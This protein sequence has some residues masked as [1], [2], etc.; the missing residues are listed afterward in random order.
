MNKHISLRAAALIIKDNKL[1]FAKNINHPCFYVI[2]GGIEPGE[3]SEETVV[4]ELLEE[5]GRKIKIDRLAFVQERFHTVE[6]QRHHEIVFFY[7]MKAPVDMNINDNSF[8]DQGNQE[9]L[10]WLPINGLN[11]YNIIPEFIKT[12][13]FDQITGIQHIIVKE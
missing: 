12:Q 13:S 9:T 7:F 10:H 6:G 5:T 2:G 3:T 1:L 11:R 4:R 8:T